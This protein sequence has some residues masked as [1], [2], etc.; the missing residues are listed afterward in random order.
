LGAHPIARALG[1]IDSLL[2]IVQMPAGVPTATFR[3]QLQSRGPPRL[4][5]R[6][7]AIDDPALTAN[8]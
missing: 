4:A 2:S 1:G 8:L 6:M 5:V 7:L 3:H